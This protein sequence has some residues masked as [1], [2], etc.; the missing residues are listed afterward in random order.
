[1]KITAQFIA[2]DPEYR[3]QHVC[4]ICISYTW[5]VPAEICVKS[6]KEHHFEIAFHKVRVFKY[7]Q[8][9]LCIQHF[10]LHIKLCACVCV[11]VPG[12]MYHPAEL[13][14]GRNTWD[15]YS[16]GGPNKG[17]WAPVNARPWSH[18]Q[19]SAAPSPNPHTNATLAGQ[20][21]I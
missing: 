11:C 9:D 8:V 12:C 16:A 5:D 20:Y 14:S 3:I 21:F 18:T 10:H 19:R 17:Q 4:S 13:Y 15:S 2:V 6:L 1:M 7:L